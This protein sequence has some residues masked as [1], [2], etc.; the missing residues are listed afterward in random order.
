V[1]VPPVQAV[2][3][4][5]VRREADFLDGA[6]AGKNAWWRWV[7]GILVI[8]FFWFVL[9]GIPTVVNL[10]TDQDS[11]TAEYLALNLGFVCMLAGLWVAVRWVHRRPF[12]TLV[13]ADGGFRTGLAVRGAAFWTAGTLLW[14]A[15]SPVVSGT[16]YTYT[17][18]PR[19]F[20][21]LLPVVLV[22]TT[23]QATTE[24][25]FF[26]G[27]LLQ[28]TALRTR[29]VA[30]LC[31]LNGVLFGVPHL[32]NPEV[33]SGFALLASYYV[34]FGAFLAL[35]TIRSGRLELAIGAH[36]ANNLFAALVISV[37]E[38]ALDTNTVFS[39]GALSAVDNLLGAIFT[40][41]LFWFL[42][43]R[44]RRTRVDADA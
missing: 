17:L 21:L 15:I 6:R 26:R 27:Y 23:V 33:G 43:F 4:V 3:A 14:A 37:E 20:L 36:V 9:G 11:G 28:G 8:L 1:E 5:Q 22:L 19:P 44:L 39:A 2:H 10:A 16:R 35:V 12:A 7:A 38:S 40:A 34:L 41:A 32:M 13:S 18:D 24:E 25:L 30:V 29:N 31:V 42:A